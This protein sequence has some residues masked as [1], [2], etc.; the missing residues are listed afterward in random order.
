MND[1][2]YK[3]TAILNYMASYGKVSFKSMHADNNEGVS[4]FKFPF[5]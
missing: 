2:F 4:S 5:M 1:Q 3:W